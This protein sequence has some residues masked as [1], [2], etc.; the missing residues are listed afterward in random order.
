M[1]PFLNDRYYRYKTQYI[2]SI[3]L[4]ELGSTVE[5]IVDQILA[6]EGRQRKVERFPEAYLDGYTGELE[7][8]EYNW[9]TARRPVE[10]S[11]EESE[12]G[13]FAVMA[14]RTDAIR[15]PRMDSEARARYVHSAVEGRTVRKG[16]EVSIPILRRD[17]DVQA[18][19]EEL[20]ADQ[21]TVAETD[22]DALERE[23]DAI[24]YDLFEL[25][26]EERQVIEDFL[27]VF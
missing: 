14:G 26:E 20:V 27:Q 15:D 19:L 3:P 12:D 23:I 18:L 16:E 5:E 13:G 24:V 11:I 4:P 25:T 1:S 8:V 7:Y 2:E 9:Q 21:Q 6:I 22:I 10:A 17:A